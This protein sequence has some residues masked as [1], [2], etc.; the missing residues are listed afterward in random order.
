MTDTEAICVVGQGYVGL[1]LGLAFDA[2]GY[3]VIGYDVDREKIEALQSGTDPTGDAGD[4]AVGASDVSFTTDPVGIER[5]DYVLVTVPTPVDDLGNPNLEFV[6]SAAHTVGQHMAEGTTVVLESTVYPGVTNEVLVPI[7][8]DQAR[9]RAREDFN[10]GYSPERLS[11]GDEGRGL[12][13]VMKIVSG[14][15]DET[16]A[17]LAALYETVVDA[18]VYRASSIEA[19]EAA[20]VMEN[21][22][23][24]LNIALAN[25]LALICD[26][27]GIDTQEVLSAAGTKWNFHDYS[28]GLVGGHCIPVDPL[29]LA[30]GSERAGYSPN[31][32]I[33]GREVN[34]Y[35]P[36]HVAE[37][38]LKAL[39][40]SGKVL[41][42]SRL[43]ALGL[44][45]KPNVGDIRTSEMNRVVSV[46]QEYGIEMTGFDPH[47]DDDAMREHFG[48][49]IQAELS[50]EG[51]DGV[52]LGT[53]HDEL[54]SID[55]DRA[56][57]ALADDPVLVDVMGALD[58][59]RA[60]EA[61][62]R[63]RTL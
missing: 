14:D 57:A 44:S 43:L 59:E 28:P 2:E 51:F 54:T 3:D 9:L 61:G 23:R 38:A 63:Y 45:Y 25:E 32:I 50:F 29:Y 12:R 35:M 31:L 34:E 58:E 52:V 4:E 46:L 24:D 37:L 20:K 62:V 56:S 47:A 55:P 30:H 17:D 10:V 5:G 39:N 48:I 22:Q 41:R 60:R 11:P 19:A 53:P 36:K 21:V 49:P 8:E 13:E 26:H 33:Q 18:G 16:L 6:E 7:L 27:M 15:T 40:E 42:E 1:P